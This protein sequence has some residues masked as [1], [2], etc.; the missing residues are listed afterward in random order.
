[1]QIPLPAKLF[2]NQNQNWNCDDPYF[3]IDWKFQIFDNGVLN[4]PENCVLKYH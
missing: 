1:M 2:I 3:L 4:Q